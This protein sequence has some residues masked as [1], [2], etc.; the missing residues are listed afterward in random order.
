M[1]DK[2]HILIVEDEFYLTEMISSRLE[3]AGFQ[4]SQAENGEDAL[5]ALEELVPD[6]ILMD[7]MMPVLDGWETTRK[8]RE[9]SRFK[10]TPIVFLS[11][12]AKEEDQEKAFQAGA[13][14]YIVKPFEFD[15]VLLM[16]KKHLNS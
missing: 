3:F 13:N 16:I 4:V 10:E 8:I 6:L 9:N 1:S 5:N 15:D 12:R 11:A 2:K 14:D 7:A